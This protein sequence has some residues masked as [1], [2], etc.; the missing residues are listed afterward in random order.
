MP[1]TCL[2]SDNVLCGMLDDKTYPRLG[3]LLGY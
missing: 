1:S 3:E 2:S